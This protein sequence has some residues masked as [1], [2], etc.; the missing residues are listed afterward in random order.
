[1]T[2]GIKKTESSPADGVNLRAWFGFYLLW[3][4]LLTAATRWGLAEIE[5]RGSALGWTVC[6]F[7]GFAGY[8]SLCCFFF[9]APTT[10]AVMLAASAAV[11][12]QVGLHE[13]P[14][15]HVVLVATVGALSTGLANLN[16]YHVFVFLL[17]LGKYLLRPAKVAKLRENRLYHW[18]GT[19]FGTN[20]FLILTL[21]GFIPIPVDVIRWL[22]ITTRYPRSRFFVAYFIGRWLRYAIWAVTA[23]EL[24]LTERQ[25][26]IFQ[27]VLVLLIL[28][29]ILARVL[30]QRRN[31]PTDGRRSAS[32]SVAG[33][34]EAGRPAEGTAANA[35]NETPRSAA[36]GE[37]RAG[38]VA[39]RI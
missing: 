11:A 34:Q 18:A 23:L 7:A 3:L 20:P 30:R 33:V 14:V 21:V 15:W 32:S 6:V 5:G 22:A 26:I 12:A 24:E 1:M 36:I 28:L 35:E 39:G 27:C 31:D 10:V 37:S 2:Q 38:E 29:K 25:I 8:M 16:E 9:P 4:A 13:H 19:K 17:R